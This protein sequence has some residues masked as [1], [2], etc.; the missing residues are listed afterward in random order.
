MRG[1]LSS[2]AWDPIA[3]VRDASCCRLLPPHPNPLPLGRG[4]L[5]RNA[6]SWKTSKSGPAFPGNLAR[7]LHVSPPSCAT[8]LSM[9]RTRSRGSSGS[10]TSEYDLRRLR[11]LRELGS[12]GAA[13]P[14]DPHWPIAVRE[15]RGSSRSLFEKTNPISIGRTHVSRRTFTRA[16]GINRAEDPA[17]GE[18][19][20]S[21]SPPPPPAARACGRSRKSGRC[22]ATLLRT[23]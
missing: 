15:N 23:R 14:I 2:V 9:G 16:I 5:T 21:P 10:L 4:N 13:N 18:T 11:V 22:D 7:P 8:A 20:S 6:R 12:F 19:P 1:D 3:L 17:S